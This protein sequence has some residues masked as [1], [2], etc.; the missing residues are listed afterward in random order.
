MI[1][2]TKLL[3]GNTINF[4]GDSLRYGKG[5]HSRPIVVWNMTRACNLHC[6]HCY[7]QAKSE[8]DN[9]ELTTQEAKQLIDDLKDFG[10]PVLLFSGGEPLLRKDIFELGK[11]AASR[12]IRTAVSTN[13]TLITS[14]T[15]QKLKDAGFGYI[16]I[17]LDGMKPVNDKFRGVNG[18]FDSTLQGIANC[19]DA[20]LKTGIRFTITKYNYN[21]VPSIINLTCDNK[22]S[23]ICF[24]HL[25]YSGRGSKLMEEALGKEQVRNLMTYI[26][27]RTEDLI[28]KGSPV[29]ILTVDN[30]ADGP[31]L[32]MHLKKKNSPT[33]ET[34]GNLLGLNGGNASGIGIACVDNIGEVHPDQFWRHHSFGNVR[35]RKFGDIWLDTN[36]QLMAGL[37]GRKDLLKGNCSKSNCKW[38]EM[39]NGNFRARA[40]AFFGDKW[41]HDPA[42][43]LTTEEIRA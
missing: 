31:Y 12:G 27:Q 35:K 5:R 25:V 1:N 43:Y 38:I 33:A 8:A 3:S 15:A 32:Y 30:H 28:Q 18:A 37:K 14:D 2:C 10:V 42:C 6:I 40:E 20:G 34:A 11:Y 19:R 21:D 17:S 7:A 13:G 41:E 39:C 4:S 16:G 36:S 26:F 24:Y 29:E 9:D 22:I 23:R